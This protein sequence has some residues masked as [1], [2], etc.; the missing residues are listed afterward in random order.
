M[1]L[2]L[3]G[4]FSPVNADESKQRIFDDANLLTENEIER[5]EKLAHEHSAKR[6]TDFIIITTPDADGK[7]IVRFV[8]DLYDEKAFG[9][10]KPNGNAAILVLDM[11]ERDVYLA[12][13]YKGKKNLDSERMNLIRGKIAPLLSSGKYDE[14]FSQFIETGSQ[15]IRY[16]PGV[17]PESFLF[18]TWFHILLA[19]GIA[20]LV[21]GGMAY[22]SGGKITV[23]ERTYTG[24]FNV[25]ERKDIFVN[26]KVTRRR[27]PKK[28]S[29]SGGGR[30]G[31]GGITR[32]GHSHSGSRGKF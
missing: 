12:G 22:N 21:V 3:F 29:S 30:G 8:Q 20:A 32:G 15:Y 31:G 27:K 23:N 11:S 19:I 28:N 26:K 4:F 14:A 24:D 2:F 10:D 17:N 9:Y 1:F 16:I 25:L 18:Q 13:F 5:L 6:K 7:D